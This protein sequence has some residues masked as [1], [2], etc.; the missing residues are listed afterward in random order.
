M[1]I[2]FVPFVSS[3][4]IDVYFRA[5]GG[6]GT[7]CAMRIMCVVVGGEM[8]QKNVSIFIQS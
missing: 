6:E 3:S 5:S 8:I 7:Q 1:F 4:N 2:P